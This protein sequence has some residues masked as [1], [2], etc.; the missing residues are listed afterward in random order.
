MDSRE[1]GPEEPVSESD[2]EGGDRTGGIGSSRGIGSKGFSG[3]VIWTP[4]YIWATYMV[5]LVVVP[6]PGNEGFPA[7]I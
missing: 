1:G 5:V 3:G 6:L 7:S 4:L 2:E